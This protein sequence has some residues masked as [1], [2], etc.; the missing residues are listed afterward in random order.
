M[1]RP[2]VARNGCLAFRS[3]D[4]RSRRSKVIAKYKIQI[5]KI[6]KL[7]AK[8]IRWKHLAQMSLLKVRVV[9]ELVSF[10]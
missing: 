4:P 1:F 6:C 5:G 3:L 10:R 8:T 7:S 9:A 2:R